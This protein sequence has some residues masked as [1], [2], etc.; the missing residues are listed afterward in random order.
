MRRTWSAS[1]RRNVAWRSE[2]AQRWTRYWPD[3]RTFSSLPQDDA[4]AATPSANSA[5]YQMFTDRVRVAG[6]QERAD[7]LDDAVKNG[8]FS[9]RRES[10]A[11]KQPHPAPVAPASAPAPVLSP[12]LAT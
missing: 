2:I 8:G 5:E 12:A 7:K 10:D 1:L 3:S 11:P 9:I 6:G 4:A